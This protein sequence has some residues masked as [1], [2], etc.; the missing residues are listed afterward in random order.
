M[1]NRTPS[2]LIKSKTKSQ[3]FLRPKE[4]RRMLWLEAKVRVVLNHQCPTLDLITRDMQ[5][6][7]LTQ[8]NRV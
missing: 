3:P 2:S 5:V 1:K 6:T 8:L 7:T 4:L